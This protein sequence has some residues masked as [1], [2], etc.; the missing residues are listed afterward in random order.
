[1][2][3]KMFTV[4]I[5]VLYTINNI[6]IVILMLIYNYFAKNNKFKKKRKKY[7]KAN[8]SKSYI[9]RIKDLN[10][11]VK[12]TALIEDEIKKKIYLL[13]H[14]IKIEK[15]FINYLHYCRRRRSH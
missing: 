2:K 12:Y 5:S 13:F 11:L 9:F 8:Y 7:N 1:M 10:K 3:K 14:Y 4:K 6:C 15:I